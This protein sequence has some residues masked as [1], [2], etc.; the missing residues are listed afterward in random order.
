M[1]RARA[2]AG[3]NRP[4][5]K[6]LSQKST[7]QGNVWAAG[8]WTI[9]FGKLKRKRGRPQRTR[10]LIGA[11]AEKIPFEALEAVRRHDRT[12]PTTGVYVAHDSMGVARYV[13]RGNV[14]VRLGASRRAHPLELK[15]FSF[16][17][18]L[19]PTHEREIETLLIR[20]VGAQLQFNTRKK[21]VD[22]EPGKIS[23]YEAGTLFFERQHTR[24]R[25][26]SR[27]SR[28]H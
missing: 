5:R 15:Y 12:I 6:A 19:E 10:P 11:V 27:P 23:D 7:Q 21:R 18:G 26:A 20:A 4:R 9:K 3:R 14:F 22:I 17:V 24:G 16:Y 1:A 2:K 13:G 8:G 28:A 25:R